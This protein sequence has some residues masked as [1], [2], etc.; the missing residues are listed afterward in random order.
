MRLLERVRKEWFMVGI[1]VAIGAAW[2][3]PAVGVN[4]GKCRTSAG[5][6]APGLREERPLGLGWRPLPF[7]HRDLPAVLSEGVLSQIC[8][9]RLTQNEIRNG[10]EDPER[11]LSSVQ[12]INDFC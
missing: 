5:Y 7:A 8:L 10:T 3:E 4:G 1:V 12:A 6:T 11:R 9:T 2:L